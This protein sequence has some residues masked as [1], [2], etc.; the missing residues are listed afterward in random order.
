MN[1]NQEWKS[2]LWIGYGFG[3]SPRWAAKTEAERVSRLLEEV[4]IATKLEYPI[5]KK[6]LISTPVGVRVSVP[7]EKDSEA[8][9]VLRNNPRPPIDSSGLNKGTA[10]IVIVVCV[11]LGLYVILS[12]IS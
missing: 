1:Q 8:L 7:F 12:L 4:G 9:Q 2:V 11:L 6:W 5:D 10:Y 3:W